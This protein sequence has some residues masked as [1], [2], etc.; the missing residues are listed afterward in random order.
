MSGPYIF[1]LIKA[2]LCVLNLWSVNSSEPATTYNL[3]PDNWWRRV[4][5]R[6]ST[7]L[8]I[9]P[10]SRWHRATFLIMHASVTMIYGAWLYLL[11]EWWA[12]ESKIKLLYSYLWPEKW[13]C[14]LVKELGKAKLCKTTKG[15]NTGDIAYL[16][17]E[18]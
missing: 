7:F 8:A 14:S 15:I 1:F 17:T 6:H 18:E 2:S 5:Q 11:H 3:I 4:K 9:S 12:C 13:Q 10:R 16:L